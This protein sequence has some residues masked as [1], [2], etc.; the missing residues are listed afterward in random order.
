MFRNNK[1]L[2][3]AFICL[4][5]IFITSLAAFSAANV[6]DPYVFSEAGVDV[7][8]VAQD[9]DYVYAMKSGD[10]ITDGLYVY[11]V[12]NLTDIKDVTN[13]GNSSLKG[14]FR[15][16]YGLALMKIHN[17]YLYVIF[18]APKVLRRYS[19]QNPA[20]P[21]LVDTITMSDS[22]LSLDISDNYLFVGGY[23]DVTA[24]S[25]A[26]T[27]NRYTISGT[28]DTKFIQYDNNK[29]YAAKDGE[30]FIID[31]ANPA[32]MSKLGSRNMRY[33]VVY[34][35]NIQAISY[36]NNY[37][38]VIT[39][40][41]NW[42]N[43]R[44]SAINVSNPATISSAQ[45]YTYSGALQRVL[46]LY[47]NSNVLY[48]ADL[49]AKLHIFDIRD[50]AN[51]IEF[52]NEDN[53][54]FP[55]GKGLNV[56]AK[57]GSLT[58]NGYLVA[59]AFDGGIRIYPVEVAEITISSPTAGET[60]STRPVTVSGTVF[61][62]SRV[63]VYFIKQGNTDWAN[64]PYVTASVTADGSYTA[65]LNDDFLSNGVYAVKAVAVSEFGLIPQS[66]R[67]ATV[68]NIAVNTAE[69][70]VFTETVLINNQSTAALSAGELKYSLSIENNSA[71]ISNAIFITAVYK[72]EKMVKSQ[73]ETKNITV[74]AVSFENILSLTAD[75]ASGRLQ[76][77]LI[78]K[79]NNNEYKLLWKSPVIGASQPQASPKA[80]NTPTDSLT[81]DVDSLHMQNKISINAFSQKAVNKD[82]LVITLKPG[83][84]DISALD[85][86]AVIRASENGKAAVELGISDPAQENLDY[87]VLASL[88]TD[89]NYLYAQAQVKYFGVDTVRPV[90]EAIKTAL[91]GLTGEN[92]IGKIVSEGAYLL[93]ID[94][95]AGSEY[96]KLGDTYKLA[97]LEKLRG[98][99]YLVLGVV[100]LKNDFNNAVLTQKLLETINSADTPRKLKEE[101]IKNASAIGVSVSEGSIFAKLSE[102]SIQRLFDRISN[103]SYLEVSVM[104]ENITTW[105]SLEYVNQTAYSSLDAVILES[106]LNV[107]ISLPDRIKNNT[108]AIQEF[109]REIGRLRDIK[110]F[111]TASELQTAINQATTYILGKYPDIPSR[112]SGGGSSGTG[113]SSSV[114]I[115][116]SAMTT[117]TDPIAEKPENG[118]FNDLGSVEWARESI[119]ALAK[120]EVISG[121][122]I[123]IFDPDS[124]VTREEFTKMIVLAFS[125]QASENP[126]EFLDVEDS[127][128]SSNYIKT[129]AAAGI[130]N[131]MENKLF[132]PENLLT[133][134]D[135]CVILYR[136]LKFKSYELNDGSIEQFADNNIISE[137]ASA[138]VG[139][140]SAEGILSGYPDG[141]F[142]PFDTATR[143]MAA[144]VIYE[145]MLKVENNQ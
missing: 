129:A 30:I 70:Y 112:P 55:S 11:N 80:E 132:A 33:G 54:A 113:Q 82:I 8:G 76:S 73:Q 139:A 75:D 96:S 109:Y 142:K 57:N 120:K 94:I 46:S 58:E 35:Q 83:S 134:Q 62:T 27:S 138:A 38:Y 60:I 6:S 121:K 67:E 103:I 65:V 56:F 92:T 141:R 90:L 78:K 104:K 145:A 131:G 12:S 15:K 44:L 115:G 5:L 34:S 91:P 4:I 100:T 128:W 18:E 7:W 26:D 71:E 36:Y 28:R 123:G 107:I 40:D 9:G 88:K 133:R 13:S 59:S 24:I 95:T 140:L 93:A 23:F 110:L 116:S 108:I 99:D 45:I 17:G 97:V 41:D 143:A 25:L 48:G 22:L 125:I 68:N 135:M 52:K 85:N 87:K 136:I 39:Y 21:A 47:A 51:I 72:N 66:A 14:D 19:L 81:L 106:G 84:T 105:S 114:S 119:E 127:R 77:Y 98:K 50:P 3:A 102:A 53:L 130:I 69:P 86:I 1:R 42:M 137:Y 10:S 89:L 126:I 117:P 49:D 79:E 64:A 16:E 61:G 29:L 122:G 43:R 144:K 2:I 37:L 118:L 74:G 20:D 101:I 124:F 32:S 111:E 63:N 31:A